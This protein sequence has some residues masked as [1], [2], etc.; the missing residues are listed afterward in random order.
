MATPVAQGANYV[1][2]LFQVIDAN[3]TDKVFSAVAY[4]KVGENYVF[5]K[6][7]EYS[8]ETLAADYLANRNYDANTADGSLAV[9][10]NQQA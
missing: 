5:F 8:A 9:L 3:D 7:V 1:W 2:N 6:Q 4:I 10:A